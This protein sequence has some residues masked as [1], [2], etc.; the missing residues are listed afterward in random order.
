MH[1]AFTCGDTAHSK[2]IASKN[3][4]FSHGQVKDMIKGI[5]FAREITFLKIYAVDVR[6]AISRLTSSLTLRSSIRISRSKLFFSIGEIVS[7][8]SGDSGDV[9]LV[10][11]GA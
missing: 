5:Q 3:V 6:E 4:Q 7:Y 1:H 11:E 8:S 10:F 9:A 2:G